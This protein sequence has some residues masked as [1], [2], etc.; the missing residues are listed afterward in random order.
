MKSISKNKHLW[1][2]FIRAI[3]RYHLIDEGDKIAVCVSGGKDS[4]ALALCMQ[5]LC[6]QSRLAQRQ[7][8]TVIYLCMDPG[9]RPADRATIERTAA[10]LGIPLDFFTA[11]IFDVV[12][13][14]GGA[15]CYLCARMRRGN[16]YAAA[17][18]RGCNKIALAHHLDDI[19]ETIMMN[20]T[21]NA[22]IKTMPVKI[23]S[24]NFPGMT[25]IRPFCLERERDIIHWRD[26]NE[27]QFIHCGCPLGQCE[28]IGKRQETKN[29]LAQIEQ[30]NPAAILN[31]YKAL[32]RHATE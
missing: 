31:I 17:Q 2:A 32:D 29:W 11:P 16:L 1:P 14:A 5:E 10:Q 3:D 24:Q 18:A 23:V 6:R 19:A 9:Y 21:Q 30:T 22:Q 20:L 26:A 15:P 12:S 28:K 25:L 8:F 27:L 7:N 13:Q 4:F